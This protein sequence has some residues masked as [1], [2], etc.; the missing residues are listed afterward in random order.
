[1]RSGARVWRHICRWRWPNTNKWKKCIF[2]IGNDHKKSERWNRASMKV[3]WENW[4]SVDDNPDDQFNCCFKKRILKVCQNEHIGHKIWKSLKGVAWCR[5]VHHSHRSFLG[6]VFRMIMMIIYISQPVRP[7]VRLPRLTALSSL[8][9]LLLS[10]IHTYFYCLGYQPLIWGW[11]YNNFLKFL[12]YYI[13]CNVYTHMQSE[14]A[15]KRKILM[16]EVE[17]K[18]VKLRFMERKSELD[19]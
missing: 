13:Y 9:F 10:S 5:V 7:L 15:R 4:D 18:A 3:T 1:M 17:W 12:M 14:K 8:G 19:T 6:T 16:V 2:N 11:H